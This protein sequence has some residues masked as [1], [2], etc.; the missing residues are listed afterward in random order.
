LFAE[1]ISAEAEINMALEWLVENQTS[2]GYWGESAKTAVVDTSEIAEY[3]KLKGIKEE[4]LKKAQGWLN[5]IEITNNDFAGRLLPYTSDVDKHESI[6]S[7]IK[8]T[9]NKDGGWGIA[10]GYQSD[11]LDTVII[12]SSL[13]KESQP[14]IELIKKGVN[15]L[16][17]MQGEDGSWSY[18]KESD[19]S[20]KL[21]AQVVLCLNEFVTTTNLTSRDVETSMRSAGEF[22]LVKQMADE[23]WGTG[24]Q[25]LIDTLMAYRAVLK[26]IGIDPVKNLDGV[27]KSLQMEDGSW[28]NNPY[29]TI[30]AVKALN[31]RMDMPYASISDI[32]VYKDIDGSK[33]ESYSFEP[34][35]KIQ[36]EVESEYD[37]EE[38]K[39]LLFIKEKDGN[40]VYSQTGDTATW[41]TMSSKPG[42]YTMIAMVKDNRGGKITADYEKE[43]TINASLNIKNVVVYTNPQSTNINKPVIVNIE[44]S[45][46][47]ESNID[48]QLNVTTAVYNA[49]GIVVNLTNSTL[50]LKAADQIASIGKIS[51]EP[52]ISEPIEYTI[53]ASVFDGLSKIAE[54]KGAFNV[55]PP[56]PPTRIDIEQSLDKAVLY[57]GTDSVTLTYNLFGEGTPEVPQRNPID[58]VLILDS[59]GSMSGTPWRKTKEAAKIISDVILPQDR[60]AI[61]DFGSDSWTRQE[62]T[63]NKELLKQVIDSMPFSNGGTAVDRGIAKGIEVVEAVN[64][65]DRQKIFM[66]LSDGNPNNALRAKTMAN[67]AAQKGIKIFTLGLGSGVNGNFLTEI[68]ALTGGK[69]KFSPTPEELN[70]IM[71]EIAG[72]IFDTAGK[73]I[74][75]ETTIPA[76][77]NLIDT[78]I[79]EPVPNEK[80]SNEDGSKTLR[81]KYDRL[82]MGQEKTV[83]V[84]FKGTNLISDTEIQL[85]EKTN[86]TY[87]DRNDTV[88]KLDLEDLFLDVN[89][90]KLR[91]LIKTDKEEYRANESV[92]TSVY[93]ENL[94]EY[95]C[96]LEEIV[97]IL[98]EDGNLVEVIEQ[99]KNLEWQPSETLINNYDWNTKNF[100]TGN[101]KIKATWSENGKIISS[102]N[103]DFE[104]IP[105]KMPTNKVSTDKLKYNADESVNIIEAVVNPSNNAIL[106]NLSIRTYITNTQ[107]ETVWSSEK[108]VDE[109]MQGET[110]RLKSSWNTEQS[111]PGLYTVTSAVYGKN[112]LSKAT[113]QFEILGSETTGYGIIGSLKV[114]TPEINT[115]D[116]VVL[117][118]NLCNSGNKD[119][120]GAKRIVEIIDPF[121]QVTIDTIENSVDLEMDASIAEE[122]IW[123]H[124]TLKPGIYLVVE[125][126]ILP[127]NTITTIA[128]SGFKVLPE[129]KVTN[130]IYTDKNNYYKGQTVNITDSVYNKSTNTTLN[131]LVL[132]T[133]ITNTKDEIVW[134][135]EN[136]LEQIYPEEKINK[137]SKWNTGNNPI[138]RYKIV[139]EVYS[140]VENDNLSVTGSV[141]QEKKLSE[142]M[143]TINIIE[144]PSDSTS[145][146]NNKPQKGDDGEETIENPDEVIPGTVPVDFAVSVSADKSVY[147]KGQIIT[148][149]VKYKN[150]LNTNTGEFEVRA[151]IPKYTSIED[152]NGGEVKENAIVW[153]ISDLPGKGEGQKVYKVLVKDFTEAEVFIYNT[154][155]IVS[156]RQ[157]INKEDDKSVI[158]VKLHSDKNGK[159]M[160]NAYISGYPD[161]SFRPDRAVTRAEIA[162]MFAKLM[163]LEVHKESAAMYKDVQSSHWAAGAVKAVTEAGLFKGYEDNTFR[164]DENITR[165]EL[166]VVIAKYMNFND[167]TPYELKYSD[168]K[169]HWAVNFI[170]EVSRHNIIKG[171]E[172]GTFRPNEKIKRSET[173]TLINNMLYRGPLN[174]EVSSFVDVATGH[175]AFGHIEEAA[176]NHQLKLNDNGD[177]IIESLK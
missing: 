125:K 62:L 136:K 46:Y 93:S 50:D 2:E 91:T 130:A 142:N 29:I 19:P 154:A 101:Y 150:L 176:I 132:K 158:T 16:V 80:I 68:A 116:D 129:E 147:V 30:I 39:L 37:K 69:Y 81:W 100:V 145:N 32:K 161:K 26:T 175:W 122:I 74:V 53:I 133:Y 171:Y 105:Q 98:D 10:K 88:V 108:L 109:I 118:V 104:I 45:L 127:N 64:E 121:T 87:S 38:S 128:S 9:Q 138:G 28:C 135:A 159:I 25:G 67:T 66:L 144:K 156:E 126:V 3:L 103:V 165:A 90:Y 20:I 114:L 162:A 151:E 148:Y 172:D 149:T 13:L 63:S 157:V 11:V 71:T 27:V 124:G 52:D 155:L 167:L 48:K 123:K 22:L 18:T 85:T 111:K 92:S 57:P 77:S 40:I 131:N 141:Y 152:S 24:D 84:T 143:V 55:H 89:K 14:D 1:E 41:N 59:S 113:A 164:P 8:S 51:F 83:K 54:G 96:V 34:Y 169:G 4:S 70:T 160:H 174:T 170:E 107:D 12:L 6:F 153:K 49:D 73:T 134:N 31:E 43:F 115:A 72:D 173:V 33:T 95:V 7:L 75:L 82:V 120:I 79:I 23:T 102:Q 15:Y 86:V 5:T 168:I 166:A 137:E 110:E 146:S 76:D 21:T 139:S 78:E 97:E 65:A 47:S 17:V 117:S 119:I 36:I 140:R 177:E 61:V 112:E 163:E 60:C 56:L 35:E 42:V 106:H 99:G 58:L 94:T 44:T